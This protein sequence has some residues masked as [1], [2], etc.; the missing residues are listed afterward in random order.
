[1]YIFAVWHLS[2]SHH[3][4][5]VASQAP[6]SVWLIP[7]TPTNPQGCQS[8]V[9]IRWWLVWIS[10]SLFTHYRPHR[11]DS[12]CTPCVAQLHAGRDWSTAKQNHQRWKGRVHHL[13][14]VVEALIC[15]ELL[16]VA[17][18]VPAVPSLRPTTNTCNWD[19]LSAEGSSLAEV[20]M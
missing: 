14:F 16:H 8:P 11:Q 9:G 7:F 2:C 15:R 1:M 5:A 10:A 20:T 6:K 18:W 13:A 3:H 19:G 17:L 12:I 4:V